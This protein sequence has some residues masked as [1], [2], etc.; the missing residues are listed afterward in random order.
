MRGR[1]HHLSPVLDDQGLPFAWKGKTSWAMPGHQQ[2]VGDARLIKREEDQG[3]QGRFADEQASRLLH[4]HELQA[5]QDHV[6]D[7]DAREGTQKASDAVES[8]DYA[9]ATAAAPRRAVPH[10]PFRRGGGIKAMMMS[11]FE[12]G[13]PRGSRSPGW[14]APMILSAPQKPGRWWRKAAG[15]IREVLGHV[16][17]D[18]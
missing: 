4:S 6:D 11:A 8:T 2:R 5:D 10:A 18:A 7:L 13:P 17:G 3:H 15:M 12:D 1:A 14:P 9:V 16:V